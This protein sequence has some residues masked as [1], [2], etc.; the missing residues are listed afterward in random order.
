MIVFH[1]HK[2]LKKLP[3]ITTMKEEIAH[4]IHPICVNGDKPMQDSLQGQ[5]PI[6]LLLSH[7]VQMGS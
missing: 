6:I 5:N 3:L 7:S 1:E 2:L 4:L